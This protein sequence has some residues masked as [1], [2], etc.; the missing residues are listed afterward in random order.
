[1][2]CPA[3]NMDPFPS[4]QRANQGDVSRSCPDEFVPHSQDRPGVPLFVRRSMGMPIG[5]SL[6]SL[7]E[8]SGISPIGLRLPNPMR[9]HWRV[10]WIR[11]DYLMPELFQT[12]R[13]PLTLGRS[14]NEDP[15]PRP[16]PE[17][18]GKPHSVCGN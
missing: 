5:F 8:C 10:V 1:M 16:L 3:S 11:H 7:R 6:T 2:G 9:V 14:L 15:S 12:S 17:D 18:V 13:H 4:Q